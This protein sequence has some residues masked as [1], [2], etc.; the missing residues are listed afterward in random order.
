MAPHFAQELLFQNHNLASCFLS[1]TVHP[2][3]DDNWH[4]TPRQHLPK[5]TIITY[6]SLPRCAFALPDI[7]ESNWSIRY[8]QGLARNSFRHSEP[9]RQ[10]SR[11]CMEP[12]IR[13]HNLVKLHLRSTQSQGIIKQGTIWKRN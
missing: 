2:G 7:M 11:N 3:Q 1:V 4:R 9:D 6:V 10:L 5:R 12:C 8:H 13:C